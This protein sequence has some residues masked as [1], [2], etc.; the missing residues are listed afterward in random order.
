MRDERLTDKNYI[1]Y[2]ARHYLVDKHYTTDEFLE[3]VNRIK[4]IKKLVTRYIE[5]DELR[6]RL[7]LNHIIVLNNCFGPIVTC[8]ILYL[9]LK[10]QWKYIK[11]FL[12]MLDILQEKIYNVGDDLVIYTDQ[13]DM[14]QGIIDKLRNLQNAS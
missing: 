14:D 12:V 6:E 3:D 8:K 2:C 4:Y 10:S 5:N 9:K 7:I 11:P 13:I 1:L